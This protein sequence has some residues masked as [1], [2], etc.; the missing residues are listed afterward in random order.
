M[1]YAGGDYFVFAVD[2]ATSSA[3]EVSGFG[4][5]T[6]DPNA[7]GVLVNVT[8]YTEPRRI[9]LTLTDLWNDTLRLDGSVEGSVI[10]GTWSYPAGAISGSFRMAAEENVDLLGG[11]SSTS[12]KS[13]SKAFIEAEP[14][15]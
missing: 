4:V 13:L 15:R 12:G 8:G 6:N 1:N 14:S 9:N 10:R 3:G 2:V 11:L 5:L 7:G